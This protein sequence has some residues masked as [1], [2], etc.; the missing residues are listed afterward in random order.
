M[1]RRRSLQAVADGLA[2]SFAS[3]NNDADGYWA[4]G[5]LRT[6]A[7]M[8][9]VLEFVVSVIPP[10]PQP[11]FPVGVMVKRYVLMLE[12]L[13]E[14]DRLRPE[15]VRACRVIV[16]F[17]PLESALRGYERSGV[18]MPFEC[19]VEITDDRG[20][21]FSAQARSR[22][23]KHDPRLEIR[24]VRSEEPWNHE[25]PRDNDGERSSAAQQQVEGQTSPPL[26]GPRL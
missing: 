8:Q 3:R 24:S 23:R 21:M 14:A 7:E 5:H 17:N 18:G 6:L 20:R 13:L 4:L 12:R 15:W 22:V 16:S 1:A 19:R 9:G 25:A 2:G 10:D 26:A 11:P